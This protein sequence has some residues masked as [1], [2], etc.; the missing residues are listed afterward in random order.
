[1]TARFMNIFITGLLAT[2][3][4]ISG[5]H[6]AQAG[7]AEANPSFEPKLEVVA[8]LNERP[9]NVAVAMDGNVYITMHPVEKHKC[10]LLEIKKDGKIVPYP[11]KEM[12]CGEPKEGAQSIQR[13][14]GIRSTVHYRLL[15]LDMGTKEIG[16]RILSFTHSDHA[17]R[18]AYEISPKAVTPQSF[19]QDM[20]LNWTSNVMYIADMGQADKTK[21]AEPAILMLY[22]NPLREPVR[23]LAGHPSLMPPGFPMQ[24][25]GREV[26][27]MVGG[28]EEPLYLGLNPLTIDVNRNWL[29]YG[30]MGEGLIFRVP[31]DKMEDVTGYPEGEIEKYIEE[32]A[33]KPPS[34]GMTIDAAGNIYITNVRDSEIGVIDPKTRKYRTYLKDP[35]LVWPDGMTFGPDGMIYLTVNQL[36]RAA[37]FNLGKD[38]GKP[39]YYV[40]RFKPLAAGSVGR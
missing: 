19:L 17:F 38:E 9:A 35:R 23:R 3:F 28:R 13:A 26:K 16:P 10:R 36:N 11:N 29:Y 34:D 15:V 20:A 33:D 7:A 18:G 37:P 32:Y 31:L 4:L 39:P 12:S 6:H 2:T 21:R 27:H 8:E 30:P 14:I 40:V 24:A 1:M 25:E 5:V 22:P